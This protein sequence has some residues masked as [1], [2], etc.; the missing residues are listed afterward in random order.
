MND[1]PW[2]SFDNLSVSFAENALSQIEF[3]NLAATYIQRWRRKQLSTNP[4]NLKKVIFYHKRA[5]ILNI[6]VFATEK[7]DGT[8][9]GVGDDGVYYG[10]RNIVEGN[11]YQRVPIKF[12][13]NKEQILKTKQLLADLASLPSSNLPGMVVYGELMC[14]PGRYSYTQRG[15]QNKWAAFGCVF[16]VGDTGVLGGV[17]LG[18][19]L[20]KAG[21][22]VKIDKVDGRVNVLMNPLL[23][24]IFTANNIMTSAELAHGTIAEVCVA[25]KDMMMRNECEGVVLSGR[26]YLTKWKTGAEDESKGSNLLAALLRRE[27]LGF[28][29][30]DEVEFARL[31]L[32]VA[33]NKPVVPVSVK[34]A[35]DSVP[36]P[37]SDSELAQALASALSKYDHLSTYFSIDLFYSSY[38]KFA[39]IFLQSRYLI[40]F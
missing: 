39:W 10:R 14:N 8:N 9:F 18:E 7:L 3:L 5:S 27:D 30:A 32:T 11:S 34:S 38:V 29:R 21:F 23:R 35:K 20:E 22:L 40:M 33:S 16:A 31:L 19:A 24:G 13:A 4:L 1:N 36:Q 6:V 17:S 2:P 12:A 15:Y 25:L 26:G 37:Y 28:L